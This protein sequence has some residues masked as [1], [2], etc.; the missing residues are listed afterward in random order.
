MSKKLGLILSNIEAFWVQVP[1]VS[2]PESRAGEKPVRQKKNGRQAR[3]RTPPLLGCVF[4]NRTG[5]KTDVEGE[6]IEA[7]YLEGVGEGSD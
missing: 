6:F 7:I 5:K 1:L 4:E 3:L 2:Q